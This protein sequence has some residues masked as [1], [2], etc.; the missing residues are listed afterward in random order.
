[1][2]EN[3]KVFLILCLLVRII[4]QRQEGRGEGGGAAK[5]AH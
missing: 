1:M 5:A 2:D 4:I 3:K